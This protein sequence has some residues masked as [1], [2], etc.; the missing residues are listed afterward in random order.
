MRL[1]GAAFD[2]TARR[3]TVDLKLAALDT[4][5]LDTIFVELSA[6]ANP[7]DIVKAG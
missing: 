3:K 7:F 5:N 4:N 1:S 2:G 6:Q